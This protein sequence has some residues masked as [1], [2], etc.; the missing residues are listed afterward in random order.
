[1]LTQSLAVTK[2]C[3]HIWAWQQPRLRHHYGL[4]ATYFCPLI[5]AFTSSDLPL[6]IGHGPLQFSPSHNALTFRHL[7]LE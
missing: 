2:P 4:T 7:D 1:M 3:T 5:P 6:S